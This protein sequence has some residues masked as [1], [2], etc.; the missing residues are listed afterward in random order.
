MLL[1]SGYGHGA[2]LDL[3]L[4][5]VTIH[6]LKRAE[7]PV[8]VCQSHGVRAG[9]PGRHAARIVPREEER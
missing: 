8:L 2:A 1:T 3:D 7:L 9:E 6:V 5:S 4:G